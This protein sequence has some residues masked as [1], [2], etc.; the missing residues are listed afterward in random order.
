MVSLLA[1]ISTVFGCG[2]IPADQGVTRP[3]TVTGFTTLP[4]QMVYSSAANI[5]ASFSGIAPNEAV[6]R[7]F[8]DRLVMQTQS[9]CIIVGNT[10]TG[11]CNV[12]NNDAQ[13]CTATDTQKMVEVTAIPAAHL[14]ISGTLSLDRAVRMLAS[15]PFGSHFF[16]ARA[17]VGGN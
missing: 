2:V 10:V 6:A 1:A 5:Q 9:G 14:T 16:S 17:T 12:A 13:E 15:G 3:F 7:G 11:I 8:V 4:V